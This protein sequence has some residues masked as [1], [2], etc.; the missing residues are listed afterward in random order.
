MPTNIGLMIM[1]FSIVVSSVLL[2]GNYKPAWSLNED[3]N[4]I[5]HI[6][7][8]GD[9]LFNESKYQEVIVW[10]DKAIDIDPKNVE[11]LSSKSAA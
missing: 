1:I 5:T 8:T 9:R 2:F 3:N 4:N 7:N 10:Y 11:A 6:L